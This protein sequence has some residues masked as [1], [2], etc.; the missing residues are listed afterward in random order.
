[1]GYYFF[2]HY[3][4]DETI[5]P[6]IAFI[7]NVDNFLFCFYFDYLKINNDS[8]IFIERL[9]RSI[10]NTLMDDSNFIIKLDTLKDLNFD[11][12][13][14]SYHEMKVNLIIYCILV[15][16]LNKTKGKIFD[17]IKEELEP[18]TKI[19]KEIFCKFD[20]NEIHKERTFIF[21][22][23]SPN[24]TDDD[25]YNINYQYDFLRKRSICNKNY[26]DEEDEEDG[27]ISLYN[28]SNEKDEE[29]DKYGIIGLFLHNPSNKKEVKDKRQNEYYS[30]VLDNSLYSGKKEYLL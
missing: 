28:P 26:T 19:L 7:Q 16:G 30:V 2:F 9:F 22:L 12:R 3:V 13:K 8:K 21:P 4:R 27:M 29:E 14:M 11:N 6:N 17:K 24:G 25:Y 23:R 15:N 18:L 10:K 20:N 5:D 1:M